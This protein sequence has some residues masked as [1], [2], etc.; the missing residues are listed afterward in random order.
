MIITRLSGGL[1]NQMFQY[2]AGLALAAHHRTT[3]RLDVTRYHL[4][5]EREPHNRYALAA[6]N[7]GQHFAAA[8]EIEHVRG[9]RLSRSER[10]FL[11]LAC[12]ARLHFIR[13]RLTFVGHWHREPTRRHFPGF[14]EWPAPAYLDGMWQ[15]PAYFAPIEDLIRQHFTLR[16]P[17]GEEARAIAADISS[18]GPTA[19]VHFRRGDYARNPIF[20][21][22]I[23]VLGVDYYRRAIEELRRAHP[24]VRLY[25]FSDEP[26][27]IAAVFPSGFRFRIIHLAGGWRAHEELYL[28]SLFPH[29]ILS[30][31]TFA[32]WGAWLH[33]G[34]DRTVIAPTPWLLD[35]PAALTDLIPPSWQTIPR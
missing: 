23:G 1:G 22:T 11:R 27:S 20:A 28:M 6:L 7:V 33:P 35:R 3:L 19:F 10:L 12:L 15:S 8:A 2:A 17:L 32:W 29:A 14:F 5:P 13:D 24:G 25:V 31:S 30:N 26:S 18:P 9:R 21:K 34:R 4:D 16:Y